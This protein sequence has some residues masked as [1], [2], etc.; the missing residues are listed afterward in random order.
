LKK[1][2][3]VGGLGL[4]GLVV[5]ALLS[6]RGQAEDRAPRLAAASDPM[7]N[8]A[9][10]YAWTGGS[11]INLVMDVSSLDDGSHHFGPDVLYA[12]QLTSKAAFTAATGT[13]T[14]VVVK[15]T[16][17]TAM[18]AW[19][20]DADG[21]AKDYVGGDPSPQAGIA[22]IS[23]KL[24]VFAGRRSD[25]RFV[26]AT[27]LTSGVALL[28]TALTTATKDGASCPMINAAQA[29]VIR[30]SLMSG[31]DPYATA[32]VMAIVIQVDQTLITTPGNPIVSVWGS[33]HAN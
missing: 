7:A 3:S 8:I 1:L 19:V 23:G 14:R 17:D 27:G 16:S 2:E 20:L 9:D 21:K 13:E 26:N 12:F 29:G 11:F 5:V 6:A 24:R 31:A 10:L 30:N 22:S 25:P 15:F 32:N 28:N 33:T 18:D 4:A